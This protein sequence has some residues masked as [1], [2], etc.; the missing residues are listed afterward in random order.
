MSEEMYEDWICDED[1]RVESSADFLNG[2]NGEEQEFLHSR[3]GLKCCPN[4]GEF[5]SKLYSGTCYL[6]SKS[7][8]HNHIRG[9]SHTASENIETDIDFFKEF[10]TR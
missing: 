2:L 7:S 5:V 3:S 9:T 10:N 6:C 1:F 8:T 4:C